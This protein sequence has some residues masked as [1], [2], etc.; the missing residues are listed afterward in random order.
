[1]SVET[2]ILRRQLEGGVYDNVEQMVYGLAKRAVDPNYGY[3]SLSEARKRVLE[4]FLTQPCAGFITGGGHPN[5]CPE[6][7]TGTALLEAYDQSD[8][9]DGLQC[10]SCRAAIEA[11]QDTWNNGYAENDE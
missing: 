5:D 2:A 9:I 4:P 1:M 11:E 6:F 8:D 7:L 10:A 3:A